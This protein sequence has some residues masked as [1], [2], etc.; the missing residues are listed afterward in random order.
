MKNI[1]KNVNNKIILLF[2]IMGLASCEKYLE[3][4]PKNQISDASVWNSEQN[5]DLFLNTLYGFVQDREVR[6]R[7]TGAEEAEEEDE[8]K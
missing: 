8:D 3:V 1:N 7:G 4:A 5:A 6:G 2:L